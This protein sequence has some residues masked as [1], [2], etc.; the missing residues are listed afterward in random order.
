M[1]IIDVSTQMKVDARIVPMETKDYKTIRKPGNDFGKFNWN[2]YQHKEVFKCIL[3]RTRNILGIM[4]ITDHRDPATNAIE[5]DL[6]E[7][8]ESNIGRHK[9]I[10]GIAGCLIAFA[11]RESFKRG[12]DGL[13][14]LTPKSEL[15]K[16]YRAKYGMV[17]IPP[18]GFRPEGIMIIEETRSRALIKDYL[19]YP[20]R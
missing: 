3:E 8:G 6:L 17:Y 4:S 7:V 10:E 5:I 9:I 14:F 15:I 18:I 16:H 1:R 13:V 19:E 2:D 12:H 20:R 11:C